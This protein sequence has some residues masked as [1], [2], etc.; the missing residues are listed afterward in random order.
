MHLSRRGKN[1]VL[2]DLIGFLLPLHDSVLLLLLLPIGFSFIFFCTRR[3][4]QRAIYPHLFS[5][6]ELA[7][8]PN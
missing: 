8:K 5:L 2:D 4:L 7:D 6:F 1:I 3:A